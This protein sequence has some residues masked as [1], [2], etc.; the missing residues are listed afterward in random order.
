ML[1]PSLGVSQFSGLKLAFKTHFQKVDCNS[2]GVE[3]NFLEELPCGNR[4]EVQESE[5]LGWK[6]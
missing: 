4:I 2:V 1:L 5:F 3:S 6:P